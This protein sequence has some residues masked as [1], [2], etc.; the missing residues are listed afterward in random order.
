MTYEDKSRTLRLPGEVEPETYR[1]LCNPEPAS[2]AG[3]YSIC[4]GEAFFDITFV[5]EEVHGH[6]EVF[7]MFSPPV[8]DGSWP[9]PPV[10]RCWV[11]WG[12]DEDGQY[13]SVTDAIE[14]AVQMFVD[15]HKAVF[16][17]S[18]WETAPST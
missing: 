4:I 18:L 7:I 5:G 10:E 8:L 16:E 12:R 9:D 6:A 2:H 15:R 1:I 3:R 13:S 14:V 17:R 11:P